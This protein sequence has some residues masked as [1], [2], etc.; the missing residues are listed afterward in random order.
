MTVFGL[1][2][3]VN[4]EYQVGFSVTMNATPASGNGV[5]ACTNISNSLIL[6]ISSTGSFFSALRAGDF[7]LFQDSSTMVNVRMVDPFLS[8]RYYF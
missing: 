6:A 3:V 2:A 1:P 4:V 8:F 5:N 7:T